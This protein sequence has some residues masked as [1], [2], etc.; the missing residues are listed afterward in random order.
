MA[1]SVD[2]ICSLTRTQVRN[3][4]DCVKDQN[5]GS[6]FFLST[7]NQSF[8]EKPLGKEKTTDK[9]KPTSNS[10]PGVNTEL[11]GAVSRKTR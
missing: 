5:K 6:L 1:V 3:P 7:D 11:Q 8:P 9:I 2:D 4:R 10:G